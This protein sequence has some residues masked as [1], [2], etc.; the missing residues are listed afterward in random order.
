MIELFKKY[1]CLLLLYMFY[2][3]LTGSQIKN[4]KNIFIDKLRHKWICHQYRDGVYGN[5][6]MSHISVNHTALGAAILYCQY[7][8]IRDNRTDLVS[9]IRPNRDDY[10]WFLHMDKEE[11]ASPNPDD[12]P[13]F[14][15][16]DKEEWASTNPYD[17]PRFLHINKE[18][19]PRPNLYD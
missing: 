12:Y 11:W 1:K 19:W 4:K 18:E 16:M 15:H 13:W 17:Y 5:N 3:V 10:P 14:L 8:E 2:A 7:A 9:P 6:S